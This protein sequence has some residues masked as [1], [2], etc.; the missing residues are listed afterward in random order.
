MVSSERAYYLV[1]DN[2]HA[3]ESKP[4]PN[5]HDPAE[6]SMTASW[7]VKLSGEHLEVVGEPAC[8]RHSVFDQVVQEVSARRGGRR[9]LLRT[10]QRTRLVTL[11]VHTAPVIYPRPVVASTRDASRLGQAGRT[12]QSPRA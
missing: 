2:K 3:C 11:G 4:L 1:F 6:I 7:P 5:Y 9:R 10:G 12:E 8:D